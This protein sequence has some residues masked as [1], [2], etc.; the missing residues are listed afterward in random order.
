MEEMQTTERC[1]ME[2]EAEQLVGTSLEKADAR[3]LLGAMLAAKEEDGEAEPAAEDATANSLDSGCAPPALPQSDSTGPSRDS[4]MGLA[5]R[6]S[7]IAFKQP[8]SNGETVSLSDSEDEREEAVASAVVNGQDAAGSHVQDLDCE[9][10]VDRQTSD[11]IVSEPESSALNGTSE[12]HDCSPTDMETSCPPLFQGPVTV[13]HSHLWALRDHKLYCNPGTWFK[14]ETEETKVNGTLQDE[15]ND[16][17]LLID[18]IQ[19]RLLF[20][21][22]EIN[23]FV[24]R[25]D[26]SSRFP[27]SC[28]SEFLESSYLKYGSFTPLSENDVAEYLRNKGNSDLSSRSAFNTKTPHCL[29]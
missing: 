26:I 6:P 29:E 10:L 16:P 12:E 28:V 1:E 8:L 11:K 3:G 17:E 14:D 20:S 7:D 15:G 13:S 5:R 18:L 19:G 21:R 22:L 9:M 27:L 24:I 23:S 2:T 25:G 4:P